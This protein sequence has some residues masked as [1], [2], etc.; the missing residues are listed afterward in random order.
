MA[1]RFFSQ[2]SNYQ[3]L[4]KPYII[5]VVNGIPIHTRGEKIEFEN[6]EFI[7]EKKTEIDFLRKHKAYGTEF[8]EDKTPIADEEKAF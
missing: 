3:I 7:T 2:C 8:Q 4:V 6:G 1:V 5:S